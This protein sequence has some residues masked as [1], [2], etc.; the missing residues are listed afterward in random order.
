M[1]LAPLLVIAAESQSS[2]ISHWFIGAGVLLI[3]LVL[4]GALLAFG[5]GREHT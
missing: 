5:G 1:S 3:F 4:M 2:G